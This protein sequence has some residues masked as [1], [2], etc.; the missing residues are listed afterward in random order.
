MNKR[1]HFLFF[2]KEE[3]ILLTKR[4]A[5]LLRSGVPIVTALSLMH[6]EARTRSAV[7]VLHYLRETV[8][9]GRPLST[10]LAE[11]RTVFGDLGVHL[12]EVGEAS[13]TLSEHLDRLSHSLKRERALRRKVLGALLYPAIIVVA[14]LA[15]TALLAL[16][17]FPKIIPV[18][19]GFHTQLP[20]STRMLIA[21]SS[22][23]TQYGLLVL[24]GL[25]LIA[26]GASLVLRYPTVRLAC[27]RAMLRTPLTGT[28]QREYAVASLCRTLG[29][30]IA[31][32]V[33]VVR[34]V[35]LCALGTRNSAYKKAY[36]EMAEQ[37]AEGQKVSTAFST[38]AVLFPR[39]LP[40]ML[41]VGE[42]TGALSDSLFYCADFYEEELEELSKSVAV[43]V[44][45]V[46]MI[47]M[48][49]I[50]GF[51][52]LAIITPIYSITQNLNA[53]H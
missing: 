11:F 36:K 20:L 50:V 4:L 22:F 23:C 18:F 42:S 6:D 13:G 29:T 31:S 7:H 14:T 44:E 1:P 43:L 45:P 2:S 35:E 32:E 40:Q 41:S 48:G 3:Q 19:K 53:Y 33:G 38:D 17:V 16:Y 28:L 5:L 12:I 8:A 37:I 26:I 46:L 49:L 25:A 30:L 24:C 10:G 52:A 51:V 39:L 47:V 34:A 15:I 27:D 21:L 9:S